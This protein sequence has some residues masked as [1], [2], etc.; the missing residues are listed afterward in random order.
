MLAKNTSI[1]RAVVS[2]PP[3]AGVGVIYSAC[4]VL[5]MDRFDGTLSGWITS[6]SV[7]IVT[8]DHSTKMKLTNASGVVSSKRSFTAPSGAKYLIEL[9]LLYSAGNGVSV[10]L[11]DAGGAVIATADCGL[12]ANT[13]SFNTDTVGATAKTFAAATYN[14]LVFCVDPVAHTIALYWIDQSYAGSGYSPLQLVAAKAY[15]GVVVAAL[16]VVTATAHT[17]YVYVDEVRV[18]APD[19]AIIGDSVSDG[20]TGLGATSWSGD[21]ST[22][23]RLNATADQTS[24]PAYQLGL[25]L[26][27]NTW[28][29]SRGF[30]GAETAE[31]VL[32]I[33]SLI[34]DQGFRRVLI[35]C[36]IND[37]NRG[38]SA[39]TIEAHITS[40]VNTLLAAG[41]PPQNIYIANVY[42][43]ALFDS[44]KEAVRLA[45]NA[46]LAA[47]AVSSGVR[48]VD[49]DA[50]LS[51]YS[52]NP[53][54]LKAAYD[55]GDGVH[56]NKTGYGSLAQT[57]Y[58]AVPIWGTA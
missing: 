27:A 26:G 42:A 3:P 18:Y 9:D 47:Y 36:G 39:A 52:V 13:L 34:A 54:R 25:L 58:N 51:N 22:T 7:A 28:V 30:G 53:A 20:K 10:Q 24:P 11:L 2:P 57:G 43:T 37:I 46:W 19:L 29:G 23:Y 49:N 6:G 21:P 48:L 38:Y 1:P 15:S 40:V 14:Q 33:Q 32:F 17:G 8:V 50:N 5:F 35:H 4:N 31:M 44:T 12:A 41:F 55:C 16:K 56:L 45:V